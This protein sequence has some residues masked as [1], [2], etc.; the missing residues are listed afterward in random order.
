MTQAMKNW[1]CEDPNY[2]LLVRAT[3]EDKAGRN[4][5][6]YSR[7]NPECNRKPIIKVLYKVKSRRYVFLP[8]RESTA[9]EGSLVLG[10]K[11]ENPINILE[12]LR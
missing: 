12:R 1:E 5:P 11:L 9:I 8:V 3:N 7:E 2:G 10:C 4:L 6:F